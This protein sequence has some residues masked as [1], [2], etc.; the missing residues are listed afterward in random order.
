MAQAKL[1]FLAPSAILPGK[2][3]A[4]PATIEVDLS[5]GTISA[6][7]NELRDKD[8]YGSEVEVLSL[9]NDKVL[10]PGLIE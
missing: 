8:A 5:N 7:H 2:D 4:Q 9:E 1:V 6:V 3:A 10:L